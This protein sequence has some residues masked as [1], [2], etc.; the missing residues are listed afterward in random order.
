M[1]PNYMSKYYPSKVICMGSSCRRK[2][3]QGNCHNHSPYYTSSN[4]EEYFSNEKS[5]L[6]SWGF[7]LLTISTWMFLIWHSKRYKNWLQIFFNL[8]YLAACIRIVPSI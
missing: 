6:A 4:N 5:T 8:P 2:E 1:N 3:G 7:I